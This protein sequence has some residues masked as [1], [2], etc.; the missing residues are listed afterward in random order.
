MVGIS[1]P[2]NST[3]ALNALNGYASTSHSNG[4]PEQYP[5]NPAGYPPGVQQP[6]Q[7]MHPLPPPQN[8]MQQNHYSRHPQAQHPHSQYPPP[9]NNQMPP[10]SQGFSSGMTGL[11]SFFP[12]QLFHDA[13]ALSSPVE[14]ADEPTL[15]KALADSRSRGESYKD[16]LNR[17]HGTSGHSAS[18]WKDYYLDHKDRL[19]S[20]VQSYSASSGPVRRTIKKPS[21]ATFKTE[22]SPISSSAALSLP[23]PPSRKTSQPA[24]IIGGSRRH[25]INSLTA[26]TLVYNKRLP[27]PNTEIKI[28]EPPSRSP[29]PPTNVVPHNRGGHKFTPEDRS[30]FIK[31]I[32]WRLKGNPTLA[33]H[34][35]A[36]SWASYWSNNHDLPDKILASA[37]GE[38]VSED[39]GSEEE[40]QPRERFKPIVRR[41]PKYKE[42]SSESEVTKA[43]E[44]EDDEEDESDEDL[45]IPPADESKMGETGGP[46]TPSDLGVVARHAASFPDWDDLPSKDRWGNF[47]Q[48]YP[49]RTIKSWNE[50]YRRN[51]KTIDTLAKKI[52]KL[53]AAEREIRIGVPSSSLPK[54]SWT[55][56]RIGPPRAKRKSHVEDL[57]HG[58]MKRQKAAET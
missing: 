13:L 48:R 22:S 2:T 23:V 35:S 34:H 16:A 58:E 32:Q 38:A 52:R 26:H 11:P 5:S 56:E 25:T 29:S 3:D 30:Y 1:Y 47:S 50:Y 4:Y 43:S 33:P 51:S 36:Q 37:R 6:A 49:Q 41:R 28:P 45:E 27:P 9:W 24:P 39:E 8:W 46:F 57:D 14:P 40:P 12:Q 21:V 17:L 42:S 19:D 31:F 18:L 54:P 55:V 44:D 53:D 7:S 20:A 10:A 15:V